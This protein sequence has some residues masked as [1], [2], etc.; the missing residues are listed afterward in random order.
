MSAQRPKM[1]PA[2]DR[3]LVEQTLPPGTTSGWISELNYNEKT[4]GATQFV[5]LPLLQQ[6]GAQAR[7]QLWLTPP[8]KISRHWLLQV[9]L[10]LNK[11]IEVP[12]CGAISTVNVMMKALKSGNYSVV[13]GWLPEKINSEDHSL[14]EQAAAFG[15][16]MGLIM[17]PHFARDLSRRPGN[18]LEIH[19]T[20]YH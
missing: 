18:H 12:Q 5:L 14:L 7:W 20:L 8:Q 10:P 2:L 19:S 15:Q 11:M 9:G 3:H 17:R 6:L 16:T 4:P 1:Y 13:L